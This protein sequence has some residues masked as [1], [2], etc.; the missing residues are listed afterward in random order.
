MKSVLYLGHF[1]EQ[2]AY[3][4]AASDYVESL[5]SVGV[6]VV[7]RSIKLN[8]TNGETT[9]LV[10]ELLKKPIADISHCIFH[11]LPH[12]FS[13]S[14]QFK[15]IG[16]F[17]Y[18]TSN[19]HYEWN[20]NLQLMNEIWTPTNYSKRAIPSYVNRP[21][22]IVP[23]ST[24]ITKFNKV[25][26]KPFIAE[27]EGTYKF[28]FIGEVS[29]RKNV[30]DI[31]RAFHCEF[32]RHEPV[33]LVLKVSIPGKSPDE[34]AKLVSE[35]CNKIKAE[36]R[37]YPCIENYKPEVIITNRITDQQLYGLHTY[38]DCYVSASKGENW[39]I[40]LA[41]AVGFGNSTVF[42][43]SNKTSMYPYLRGENLGRI[44]LDSEPVFGYNTSPF[45][46]IGSSREL[47][48]KSDVKSLQHQMRLAYE[49][50]NVVRPKRDMNDF[51]Y[52]KV[53]QIMKGLLSDG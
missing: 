20:K 27:I 21:V 22:K 50:R 19:S 7:C 41:D 51:S 42:Y 12:H 26:Q 35:D 29:K 45:Q 30:S 32:K 24:D 6:N 34:A 13:Y 14:N 31:V 39:N 16:M 17:I 49:N 1:H 23:H 46:F 25:Y 47:W 8:S 38:C 36:T 53:G 43:D 37:L 3:S 9:T 5:V 28:Y 2:T 11:V 10:S 4:Q 52:E 40:P 48:L 44:S 18:D 15:N 33:S